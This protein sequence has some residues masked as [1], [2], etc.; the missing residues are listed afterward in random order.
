[1]FLLHSF[2]HFFTFRPSYFSGSNSQKTSTQLFPPFTFFNVSFMKHHYLAKLLFLLLFVGFGFPSGAFAQTGSVSGRVTD[3]KNEGVPGATVLIEGTTIGGSSN[4]DG[5]Y[6]I[7]NVPAGNQ[8]LV[9]SYVGYTTVRRPVTVVAGQNTEVSASLVENT[10]QLAEAVVVGY[11]TQRR[12]DITGSVATVDERQ[13]VKGQVTNPEQLIQGKVAGLQINT[14]GGQ[15]GSATQIRIRGGSSLA[16]NNPLIVIDGVPVENEGSLSGASNPLTLINPNDIETYTVL[17]DASATAIYGSRAS[18][19]VILITTK[20]GLSGEKLHVNINSQSSISKLIKKVDVLSGDEYR[21]LINER[22]NNMPPT[23]LGTAN[24]DWQD[25][26]YQTGYTFD[27]NISLTGSAGKMPIRVSYGNLNQTGILRTSKLVRNSGSI[28]ITPMLLND[29]LRIDI[30]VKGS[31]IDNNFADQGAIG[32]AAT[33]D[34]TRPIYADQPSGFYGGYFEWLQ[35]D[36]INP[37]TIAARNPVALLNLRRDRSTV[38][39]SVGNI[40]LDYK[41][42]FLAGLRANFNLGYDVQRGDGTRDIPDYA[43]ASFNSATNRSLNGERT[44]YSQNR[45]TWLNE[46]YLNYT[47]ELGSAGRIE[48]LAGHSYQNFYRRNPNYAQFSA[49]GTERVN[50]QPARP[51]YKG[52][53]GLES[54]YGRFNYNLKD[55]YLLTGTLRAD[56]SSRFPEENRTGYFPAVSAAWRVKGEDFMASSSAISDLKLRVGYGITGQ[57]GIG[58]DAYYSY[59]PIY[60]LG[61]PTVSY[62]FGNSYVQ[63]LRPEA[64]VADLKWEETTTYNAGLDY[65]FANGRLTGS[66]D[67]YLRRSKDLLNRIQVPAG[68]NLADLVTTNIGAIENRGIEFALN[69]QVIRRENLNWNLNFN[70]TYNKNEIT[71]L[72]LQDLSSDP[73]IFT[74]DNIANAGQG[75]QIL[76]NTVGYST[77]SFYVLKQKYNDAGNPINPASTADADMVRAFED[78]NGD[79]KITDADRYRYKQAASPLFMG[80]GSN[81]SVRNFSLAFTMRANLNNYVYNNVNSGLAFYNNLYNA[82]GFYNNTT[83]DIRTTNFEAVQYRSDYYVQDASFLRMDNVTLGYNFPKFMNEKANLG[84]SFAVQNVF[85]IT[86]YKGLD[87]EIP[88]GIDNNFYPRPRT[89]TFGVNVGF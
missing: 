9:I 36:N 12:Q 8:T 82:A 59:Q 56:R 80:L 48:I 84:V 69:G 71:K 4:V 79:G 77:N 2:L 21:Q 33:F 28:G 42:P 14:N 40:Q 67:V 88:S 68:T 58:D 25:A 24:T 39:R 38:K 13:F 78:M 87:P 29:N 43:R 41:L 11:G 86:K 55:R 15:P 50:T 61:E 65:G 62:Q 83:P 76:I 85:V 16:N 81:L 37:I 60:T 27:N 45:N 46:F 72:R 73:G 1:M 52:D 47:K 44:I 5:T 66:V 17:K 6:S 89:F 49:D 75:N 7:Q 23:P 3:D 20:K 54:Y 34:P 10:T 22:Y 51:E 53:Y 35:A 19:G 74:G 63:T 32:G 57:Q 30:N 31:I 18:N 26:I 70:A 64:Y